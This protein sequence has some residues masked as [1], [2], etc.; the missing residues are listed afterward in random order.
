MK[1]LLL[2]SA[3]ACSTA[4]FANFTQDF[5]DVSALAGQGWVRNNQSSPG[6]SEPDWFQGNPGIFNSHVGPN[7]AYIAANFFNTG[8]SNATLSNWLLTPEA[9]LANG[10]ILTFWTRTVDPSALADRLQ[11]RMSTNGSSTNV[12]TGPASVG[13][14]SNLL[15]DI[16]PNY[17]IG[18]AGYPSAWTQFNVTVSGLAN[19]V[20]GRFAF[21]Y[22]VEDGGP[23]GTR[24]D[25]IGL[26]TVSYEAVPEPATLLVLGGIAAFAARRKRK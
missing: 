1:Q 3:L 21:R 15:L 19:P 9:T 14:F 11:V 22:F 5:N 10:S 24:S 16:N 7:N 20:S 13:D 4:A 6:A 18:T 12:G 2:I 25:Y 23:I 8:G 26:D 17:G